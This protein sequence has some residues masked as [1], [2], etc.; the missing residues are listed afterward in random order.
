MGVD[1]GQLGDPLHLVL[2]NSHAFRWQKPRKEP[3]LKRNRA[4]QVSD[5]VLGIRQTRPD[6]IGES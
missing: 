4:L 1:T 2:D 5:T 3:G 6:L